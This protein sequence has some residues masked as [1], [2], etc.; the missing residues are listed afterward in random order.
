MSTSLWS[1]AERRLG[2]FMRQST[3]WPSGNWLESSVM[4]ARPVEARV[5]VLAP[6]LDLAR[7]TMILMHRQL[8]SF[9]SRSGNLQASA[10]SFSLHW[11]AHPL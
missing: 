1:M 6:P 5:H 4:T 9:L 8:A 3:K 11:L 2:T 7:I 10:L